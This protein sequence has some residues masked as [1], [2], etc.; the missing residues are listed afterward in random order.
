MAAHKGDVP[1]DATDRDVFGL[2]P[3]NEPAGA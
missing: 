1:Y 3:V 2:P